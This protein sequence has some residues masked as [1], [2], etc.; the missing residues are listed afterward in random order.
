MSI[1]FSRSLIL[2]I[3]LSILTELHR[4]NKFSSFSLSPKPKQAPLVWPNPQPKAHILLARSLHTLQILY[5][6]S[7]SRFSS[8]I[9]GELQND[10]YRRQQPALPY[11]EATKLLLV[12]CYLVLSMCDGSWFCWFSKE[13]YFKTINTPNPKIPS[14]SS[15]AANPTSVEKLLHSVSAASQ[16]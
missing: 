10:P 2:R 4:L 8:G 16:L 9:H 15:C 6:L 11:S 3:L 14:F 12:F 13:Y 1:H 7:G 5:V